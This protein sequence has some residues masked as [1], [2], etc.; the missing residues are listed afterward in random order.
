MKRLDIDPLVIKDVFSEDEY[1]KIYDSV[2]EQFSS[3]VMINKYNGYSHINIVLDNEIVEKIEN[4]FRDLF[5]ISARI[6]LLINFA[7]YSVKSGHQPNLKPHWDRGL[8]YPAY[9]MSVQ[10]NKTLDWELGALDTVANLDK[11]EAIIFSGSD[12]VHYRPKI[13]FSDT[14]ELDI[15]LCQAELIDEPMLD[16]ELNDKM[17]QDDLFKYLA[18]TGYG[19]F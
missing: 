14:D 7:R 11:N 2:E 9:M 19:E 1:R 5:N 10:L 17:V 8:D 6:K 18:K 13:N 15:L 4:I 3:N 12:H 16:K